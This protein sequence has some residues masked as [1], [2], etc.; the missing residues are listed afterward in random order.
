M[1]AHLGDFG[2]AKA[3]AE[4]RQAAFGKDCTESASFFAGSYG[5]I[6]P[7]NFNG[8]LK[9]YRNAVAQATR[10]VTDSGRATLSLQSVLTP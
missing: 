9:C 10:P 4:N 5:Y 3:V 1:E 8:N 6:A 2:L 7:G